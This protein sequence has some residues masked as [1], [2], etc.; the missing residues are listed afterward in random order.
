VKE[1]VAS[2]RGSASLGEVYDASCG[3]STF[4]RPGPVDREVSR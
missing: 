3:R 1:E 2:V 4:E